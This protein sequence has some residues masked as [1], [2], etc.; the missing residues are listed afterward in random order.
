MI[1]VIKYA[2]FALVSIGINLLFQY[3][4]F[5]IYNGKFSL[6]FALI[7]GTISGL[8]IKYILDKKFIFYHQTKN[9][10]DD[11]K[12]FILYSFMGIFTT[13]I[14]WGFEIGFD[15]FFEKKYLGGFIGLT[16]GYITKYF[17][18][19]KFVFKENYEN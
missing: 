9:I 14:F 2:F 13:I 19:K 15:Y 8:I 12:K 1:L 10:K 16:I 18:D 6:F 7:I 3:F 11:S 17:L 4:S 5:F